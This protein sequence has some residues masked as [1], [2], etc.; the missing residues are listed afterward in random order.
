MRSDNITWQFIAH[1]SL[2]TPLSCLR[3]FESALMETR[4]VDSIVGHNFH[5][6]LL[7]DAP[8][9][10]SLVPRPL[11]DFILQLWIKI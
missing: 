7:Q 4:V 6:M 8:F 9:F 5:K 10:Y 2:S 3:S 11:P 1:L